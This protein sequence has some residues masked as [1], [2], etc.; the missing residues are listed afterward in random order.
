MCGF[1]SSGATLRTRFPNIA[2]EDL[3]ENITEEI[4][5]ISVVT[6]QKPYVNFRDRLLQ[7]CTDTVGR[8][9]EDTIFKTQFLKLRI[10]TN[11][12]QANIFYLSFTVLYLL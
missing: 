2:I 6:W 1:F 11:F 4:V 12:N 7:Q 9:L 8:H 10:H 3:K 5:A